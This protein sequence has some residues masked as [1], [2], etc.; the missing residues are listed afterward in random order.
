MC[1]HNPTRNGR[2]DVDHRCGAIVAV[3]DVVYGRGGGQSGPQIGVLVDA[4][5]GHVAQGADQEPAVLFD[6]LPH[7]GVEGDQS[8]G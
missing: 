7:P 8:F 5:G 6:H 3:D 4:L 1:A 2:I